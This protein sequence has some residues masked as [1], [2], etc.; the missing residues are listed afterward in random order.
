MR[1]PV[2]EIRGV[3]RNQAP[4]Q[5]IHSQLVSQLL[6]LIRAIEKL[7]QDEV[8]TP[9]CSGR[10]CCRR[11]LGRRRGRRG[12]RGRRGRRTA[13]AGDDVGASERARADQ[14]DL[15]DAVLVA[16]AKA[17]LACP[18]GAREAVEISRVVPAS[19][20]LRTRRHAEARMRKRRHRWHGWRRR[21]LAA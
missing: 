5:A 18:E 4:D 13:T 19:E 15:I 12:W 2:C 9:P 11:A 16:S 3:L 6:C 10:L 17:L 7:A 21:R 8:L 20:H 14:P 1:M